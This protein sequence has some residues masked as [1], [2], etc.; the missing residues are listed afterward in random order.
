M[1]ILATVAFCRRF[2]YKISTETKVDNNNKRLATKLG[3]LTS[4]DV[5]HDILCFNITG[6]NNLIKSDDTEL[7]TV[8][9]K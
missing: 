7:N 3:H 8:E 9:R 1:N 2:I 5:G 4:A 6:I